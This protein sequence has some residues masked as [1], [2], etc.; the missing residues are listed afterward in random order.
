MSFSND[1]QKTIYDKLVSASLGVSV[2]G[3]PPKNATY[4]YVVVGDDSFAPFDTD[5]STGFDAIATIHVW[6]N[7]SGYKRVKNIAGDI[8]E[9]LS[10]ANLSVT[11]YTVLDCMFDSSDYFLDTDGKTRHGVISFRLLIDEA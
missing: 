9:A 1:I 5:T 10:R 7:Y 2:Y 4:P 8:Y 11:G 3:D 6:D